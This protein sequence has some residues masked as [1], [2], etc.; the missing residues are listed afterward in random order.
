MAVEHAIDLDGSPA[1]ALAVLRRTAEDLGAGFQEN[2]TGGK[3][4]IPVLAGIRRG[5][6]SGDVEIRPAA[7]GSS[8]R[9][10]R[11]TTSRPRP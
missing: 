6:V 2:G 5:L 11:S 7:G 4:H 8:G 1:E 9:R 3:L 10:R